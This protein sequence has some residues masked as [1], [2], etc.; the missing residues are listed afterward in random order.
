MW[1]TATALGV[2][3][4][5]WNRAFVTLWVGAEHYSG[6]LPNLLI[7]IAAMQ[8]VFIRS[9][10]NIIDLTLNLRQK[11]LLGFLSV[12]TSVIIAGLLVGHFQLGIPGL[13]IGIMAGRLIISFGYPVVIGR[14][15]GVTFSTQLKGI[16]RPLTVTVF[17]FLLSALLGGFFLDLAW[18]GVRGWL[19]FI[20][21]ASITFVLTL[22]LVFY[23][24]LSRAQRKIIFHR[25]QAVFSTVEP[26]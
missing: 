18:S 6:T 26:M 24:G 14:F 22:L 17:T 7:T 20:L 19:I 12:I 11:V 16:L 4:L 15:L 23:A 9:D 21:S 13:C 5:L 1:L 8:L 25:I 3:I 2:S 10:G